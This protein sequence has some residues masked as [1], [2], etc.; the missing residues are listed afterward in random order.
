MCSTRTE[1]DALGVCLAHVLSKFPHE[2]PYSGK[3]NWSVESK[4]IITADIYGP[5]I[6]HQSLCEYFL[7]AYFV[8]STFPHWR[9]RDK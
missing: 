7:S 1:A 8:P 4:A 6:P 2:L 3:R 5:F 9:C